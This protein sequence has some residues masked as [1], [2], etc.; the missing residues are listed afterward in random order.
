MDGE[1]CASG[2]WLCPKDDAQQHHVR[3]S[4]CQKH[5]EKSADLSHACQLLLVTRALPLFSFFTLADISGLSN[6]MPPHA[7][8]RT[9]THLRSDSAAYASE[10]SIREHKDA[11]ASWMHN[12]G[13]IAAGLK[14]EN[15][16]EELQVGTV[17]RALRSRH[18]THDCTPVGCLCMQVSFRSQV[19]HRACAT[20]PARNWL[21]STFCSA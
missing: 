16:P 1:R 13:A 18:S 11:G 6:N 5:Q 4:E 9:V 8:C 21:T 20:R 19:A 15:W 17:L 14:F 3:C 7:S 10:A 2:R 12:Y